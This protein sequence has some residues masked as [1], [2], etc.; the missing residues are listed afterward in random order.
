MLI[1]CVCPQ[2]ARCWTSLPF[3]PHTEAT[4]VSFQNNNY[5]SKRHEQGWSLTTIPNQTMLPIR[6]MS[7]EQT[8]HQLQPSPPRRV[9]SPK[10]PISRYRSETPRSETGMQCEVVTFPGRIVPVPVPKT[11]QCLQISLSTI[12]VPVPVGWMFDLFEM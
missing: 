4:G 9:P 1:V 7:G 10:N 2:R 11:C 3:L 6:S 5:T 12:P 8:G